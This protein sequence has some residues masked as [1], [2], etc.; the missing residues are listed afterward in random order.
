MEDNKENAR[1]KPRCNDGNNRTR[2]R[3]AIYA[4]TGEVIEDVTILTR[5]EKFKRKEFFDNNEKKHLSRLSNENARFVQF[6]FTEFKAMPDL[7]PQTAIRLM[8]LSTYLSYDNNYLKKS[9][10]FISKQ[11][12]EKIIAL[13]RETFRQFLSEVIEH[14]YLSESENGYSLSKEHFN[15]GKMKIK[16]S[17]DQKRFIRVYINAIRKLYLSTHQSKHVYMGYIFQIIPYVN[18]EWNIVC[19]N[20]LEKVKEDIQ[21]M[22]LGEFCDKIGYN[23]KNAYRLIKTL[24]EIKFNWRGKDQLF[25]SYI[26]DSNK[27]NMKFFVNPNI[28]YAG[29]SFSEVEILGV[30]F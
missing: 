16:K 18:M 17:E 11:E 6:L 23:K 27:C 20:P 19:H 30:F 29:D 10:R 2:P 1:S 12:M 3:M 26:Y 21:P 28:F 4:D 13:N 15:M 5:A 7:L 22:T 8:Y 14:G 9:G 24:G 25:C